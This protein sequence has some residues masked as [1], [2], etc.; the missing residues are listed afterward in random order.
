MATIRSGPGLAFA[1]TI[2][3]QTKILS[4]DEEIMGETTTINIPEL[5]EGQKYHAFIT[6]NSESE[7]EVSIQLLQYLDERGFQ[8]C[9]A[10]RDF[11]PGTAIVENLNEAITTSLR[12]IAIV[13]PEFLN[14]NWCTF[15]MTFAVNESIERGYQVLIPILYNIRP[16]SDLLP[17]YFMS[18]TCLQ[19]ADTHFGEK[20]VHAIIYQRPHVKILEES[21][22]GSQK[23]TASEAEPVTRLESFLPWIETSDRWNQKLRELD[24]LRKTQPGELLILS[25]FWVSTRESLLIAPGSILMSSYDL[26]CF[27][28]RVY[29]GFN[30]NDGREMAVK[31]VPRGAIVK[32][33]EEV[34]ALRQLIHP[35]I[36]GYQNVEE[37]KDFIYIALDLHDF[38][39][40]AWIKEE[41][42]K[43][44]SE[45]D[46]SRKA[47]GLVE[48][49]LKGLEYLHS[50]NMLHRDLKPQNLFVV[51]SDN[52]SKKGK[53]H[54]LKLADF[55]LCRSFAQN[56]SSLQSA[57]VGTENWLPREVLDQ[58]DKGIP[59]I[60]FKEPCDIQVGG[61]VCC[62]IMSRGTHPY[63]ADGRF[64]RANS[65]IVDG[66]YDLS[67]FEDPV[68]CDLVKHMLAHE[69]RERPSARDLLSHPYLW[70][71][72]KRYGFLAATATL[73]E[74]EKSHVY[75][76][77]PL[78]RAIEATKPTVLPAP[79]DR[80]KAADKPPYWD[81]DWESLSVVAILRNAAAPKLHSTQKPGHTHS[82]CRLLWLI[83]NSKFHDD[84]P[85]AFKAELGDCPY[86][87]FS[88][89]FSQLFMEVKV[90][91]VL[92]KENGNSTSSNSVARNSTRSDSVA[93]NST[94]SDSVVRNS[95]SSDN[96]ARNSTSSDSIARTAPAATALPGTQQQRQCCQE[97]H[98]QRQRCQEQ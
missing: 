66:N 24:Q 61:M 62:Y 78:V 46:W 21:A 52:A 1:C 30:K 4:A 28:T 70:D 82:V 87:Y 19:Y 90:E 55:G 27:G 58:R 69:P 64:S 29:V 13:S 77:A 11:M 81:G 22:V 56:M 73:E 83:R 67:A 8:C 57:T 45:E 42:V 96:V 38:T 59:Q 32:V 80:T 50:K 43:N 85:A 71:G 97:Q 12:V 92:L 37:D 15:Q 98:Q 16:N 75:P 88:R 48:D 35:N 9:H 91:G 84:Q 36:V 31:I 74:V 63:A 14:S 94:S 72:T 89:N 18:M 3:N 6:H 25:Q 33:E 5:T 34:N 40:D 93:R 39:L 44:M 2:T 79:P 60:K 7:S 53:S 76:N 17:D 65:N 47:A 51:V 41:D 95:T 20:L 54:L 49:F 86:E 68:A 23:D 10:D 26:L